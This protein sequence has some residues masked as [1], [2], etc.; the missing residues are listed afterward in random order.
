MY[1]YYVQ[2]TSTLKDDRWT[3]GAIGGHTTRKD[4]KEEQPSG[5]ETTWDKYWSN[6]IWHWQRTAQ[7]RLTWCRHAEAFA[8]PRD[9]TAA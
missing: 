8:Q 9:T 7:D 5:G 2:G 3:S 4:D 6:T 1:I